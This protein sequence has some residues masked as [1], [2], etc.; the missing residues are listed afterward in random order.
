MTA[1]A[2]SI[3]IRSAKPADYD[4]IVALWQAAGLPFRPTG[5]DTREAFARQLAALAPFYLVAE[6]AEGQSGQAGGA[7]VGVVLGTHDQ[8][9]GWI[10]RLAVQ[11]GLQRLGIARRL[12]AA[13][14]DALHAHGI[15][16]VAALVEPENTTS[17]ALFAALGYRTDVPVLYFRK[18]RHRDV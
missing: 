18:L 11:P 7:L 14:E 1:G 15:D 13:C 12:V 4:D 3:R 6:L 8:R 17:A 5:R 9:K 2:P 10:N 16:I